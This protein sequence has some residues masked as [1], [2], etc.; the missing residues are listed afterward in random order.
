[1]QISKWKN[2]QRQIFI[3][4]SSYICKGKAIQL[5]AWTVP[6]GFQEVEVNTISRQSAYEGGKVFSPTHW[7]AFRPGEIP[8]THFC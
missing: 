4:Y 8:D 7:L 1:M 2:E 3:Q 6:L 5:Q